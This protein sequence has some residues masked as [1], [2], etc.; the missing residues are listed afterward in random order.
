ME[1]R[2]L[3]AARGLA[4]P[5]D[6]AGHVGLDLVDGDAEAPGDAMVRQIVKAVH[7]EELAGQLGHGDERGFH[8][9]EPGRIDRPQ[10]L[11]DTVSAE[12]PPHP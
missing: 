12:L 1:P 4:G 9:G 6:G 8:A 2:L 10:R 11:G 7:P 3:L 5:L